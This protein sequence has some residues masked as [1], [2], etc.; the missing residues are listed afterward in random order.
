MYMTKEEVPRW[1]AYEVRRPDAF[2][3]DVVKYGVREEYGD[4]ATRYIHS[5]VFATMEEA[6]QIAAR[7][8]INAKKG[9]AYDNVMETWR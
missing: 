2:G 6:E 3:Y 1:R 8:N 5:Q 7:F 9:M 4:G